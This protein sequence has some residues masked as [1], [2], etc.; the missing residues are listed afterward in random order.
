MSIKIELDLL[1]KINI[2]W[3]Q[4][5]TKATSTLCSSEKADLACSVIG[6]KLA[7]LNLASAVPGAANATKALENRTQDLALQLMLGHFVQEPW[8]STPTTSNSAAVAN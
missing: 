6:D 4:V 5:V 7:S 3:S 8:V 1:S 2:F